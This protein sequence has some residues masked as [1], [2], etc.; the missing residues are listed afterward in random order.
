MIMPIHTTYKAYTDTINTK[1]INNE[2]KNPADHDYDPIGTIK[3]DGVG[4]STT[5]GLDFSQ[6]YFV[7]LIA[8]FA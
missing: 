6:I 4:G 3:G 7:C 1:R 2:A 8:L 5:P